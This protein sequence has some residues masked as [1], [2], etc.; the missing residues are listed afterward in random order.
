MELY[1]YSSICFCAV[2]SK[3]L[4]Q[5]AECTKTFAKTPLIQAKLLRRPNR[6]GM[7]LETGELCGHVT[8]VS[9]HTVRRA[10]ECCRDT[11]QRTGDCRALLG[12]DEN[13][14]T[15][16]VRDPARIQIVYAVSVLYLT[17]N[18]YRLPQLLR[19]ACQWSDDSVR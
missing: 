9:H 15:L 17:T 8:G 18:V 12:T 16:R 5:T 10:P 3:H 2:Y 4:K 1:L 13:S 7:S 11:K 19:R 6:D 14:R